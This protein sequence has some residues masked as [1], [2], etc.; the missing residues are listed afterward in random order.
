MAIPDFSNKKILVI[1]DLMLDKHIHGSVSRISPEAPVPILKAEKETYNPG[2]AAAVASNLAAL[3]CRT[4]IAGVLGNDAAGGK[5]VEEMQKLN[6]NTESI[7]I[8]QKPTIQ[9]IRGLSHQHLFRID[10]E[11]TSPITQDDELTFLSMV[12]EILPEMDAIILSDYAKGTLTPE[13]VRNII[14]LAK[15]H[16]KLITADCKPINMQHYQNADIIK[17]NKKEALEA[18]LASSVEE[19]GRML[20]ERLNSTIV[21]TRGSEGISVFESNN[22]FNIPAKAQKIFDVAGAGDTVLAVLTLALISQYSIKEAVELANEAAAIVVSKPGVAIVTKEE[23]FSNNIPIIKK[24]WGEE[25]IIANNEKYCG[26]K[27]LIRQG[28]YSSYHMHKIKEETFY[29]A[30]GCLEVI[31]NGKYLQVKKGETLHLKPGEYHSF[32]ALEDT[33]FFE[34]ST[35]HKDEDNYRLTKSNQGSSEQWKQEIE[36]IK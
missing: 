34:F 28:F 5:L 19:A 3:G 32:R 13:L 20:Q 30:S 25:H 29:I 21:L 33:T 27:M 18:T 6:I 4:F 16:N 17:P 35:H 15:Q 9:K 7:L 10:Y 11:D 36:K 26:K 22:Q 8:T 12:K 31:H 1:G 24:A 2:G 23:L 14:A